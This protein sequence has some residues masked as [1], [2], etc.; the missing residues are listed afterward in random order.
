MWRINAAKVGNTADQHDLQPP[1]AG[2]SLPVLRQTI[3]SFDSGANYAFRKTEQQQRPS[4]PAAPPLPPWRKNN[5][6]SHSR[7]IGNEK[8]EVEP[9][10]LTALVS[11]SRNLNPFS[12][13]SDFVQHLNLRDVL[14]TASGANLNI[15]ESV[16]FVAGSQMGLCQCDDKLFT[17]R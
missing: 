13:D 3:R 11:V 9:P 17:H 16:S 2:P 4:G 15:L 6:L 10:L 14:L 12:L 5:S 1:V 8:V 7:N